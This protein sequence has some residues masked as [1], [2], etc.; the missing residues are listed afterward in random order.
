MAQE[1]G[2]D[3]NV[4]GHHGRRGSNNHSLND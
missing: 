2:L 3:I 1:V 4:A